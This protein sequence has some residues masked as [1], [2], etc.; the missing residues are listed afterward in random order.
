MRGR[1]KQRRERA[2]AR[3][4][5]ES[6]LDPERRMRVWGPSGFDAILFLELFDRFGG[7]RGTAAQQ[8]SKGA[9]AVAKLEG[10]PL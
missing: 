9:L 7:A 8:F 2:G 10:V 1:N 5:V 3:W 4:A 6:L